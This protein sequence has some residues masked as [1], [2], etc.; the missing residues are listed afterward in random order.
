MFQLISSSITLYRARGSQLQRYRYAVFRLCVSSYTLVSFVNLVV[1]T[2]I[3]GE[4]ST[5]FVL[6]TAISDEDN[7]ASLELRPNRLLHPC[8]ALTFRHMLV[9]GLHVVSVI[10]ALMSPR[11]LPFL[12]VLQNTKA[13]ISM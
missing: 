11:L 13:R 3:V 1:V 12:R 5:F 9:K 4:H 7:L 2:T 10:F 8:P 6:L